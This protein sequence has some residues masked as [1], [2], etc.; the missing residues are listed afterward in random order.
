M[1][2]DIIAHLTHYLKKKIYIG[3]DDCSVPV[4]GM[5]IINMSHAYAQISNWEFLSKKYRE[6]AKIIFSSII[7]NP[8]VIGGTNR[9]D[10]DLMK[11]S[12]GNLLAKSGADGVFCIGIRKTKKIQGMGITI[13]MESGNMKFLPMAVLQILKQLKILSE[14]K[15][16]ILNKYLPAD[17]KNYRNEKIGCFVTDFKLIK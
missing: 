13:K 16:S 10:T 12:N 2:L 4:F 7:K 9:F 14:E 11:I 17:K 8:D 1:I 3:I 6:A 5:P 15:V